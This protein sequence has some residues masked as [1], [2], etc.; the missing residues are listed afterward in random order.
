M[1]GKTSHTNEPAHDKLISGVGAG[2]TDPAV[3]AKVQKPRRS[4]AAHSPPPFYVATL[5]L[6]PEKSRAQPQ[7]RTLEKNINVRSREAMINNLHL[8]ITKAI[9]CTINST[10]VTLEK[11]KLYIN[12]LTPTSLIL[13]F[14]LENQNS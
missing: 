6:T 5:Q 11:G 8:W 10:D 4:S 14:R 7:E 12:N 2:P 9:G 13:L 3:A 1:N